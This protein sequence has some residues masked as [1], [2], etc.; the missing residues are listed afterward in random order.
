MKFLRKF[1]K[2]RY[3][4]ER[5]SSLKASFSIHGN[6]IEVVLDWIEVVLDWIEVVLDWIE[7]VPDWLEAVPDWIEVVPD[8][9]DIH[10]AYNLRVVHYIEYAKRKISPV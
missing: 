6:W 9:L 2:A 3:F 8:W 4:R 10:H 7:V 1:L 5:R